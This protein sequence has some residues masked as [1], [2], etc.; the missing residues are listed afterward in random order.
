MKNRRYTLVAAVLTAAMILLT[1][2]GCGQQAHAVTTASKPHATKPAATPSLAAPTGAP[3]RCRKPRPA[4]LPRTAG[5]LSVADSGARICLKAGE[6][7]LAFLTVPMSEVAQRWRPI[8]AAPANSLRQLPNRVMTLAVNTT[9]GI[10]QVTTPGVAELTSSRPNGA[11][12]HVT[13]VVH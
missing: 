8:T 9:A 12:W 13:L 5:T 4:V 11:T 7:V 10:L 6:A 1:T 3:G 2:S